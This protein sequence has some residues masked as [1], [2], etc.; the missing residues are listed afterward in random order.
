MTSENY[1]NNTDSSDRYMTRYSSPIISRGLQLAKKNSVA[2]I[3]THD[4]PLSSNQ[5][6]RDAKYFFNLAVEQIASSN[7]QDALINL[8]KALDIDPDYYDAYTVRSYSIYIPLGYYQDAIDDY[9]Q[10]LRLNPKNV[11]SLTNRGWVYAQLGCYFKAFQDYDLAL[12]V[13]PDCQIAYMNRGLSY[14]DCKNYQKAINDFQQVIEINPLNADAYHNK[15]LNLISLENYEHALIN[16]KK[17]IGINSEYINAHL[18]KGLCC[19]YLEKINQA[20]EAFSCAIE[21]N[22][23]YAKNYLEQFNEH[24][25]LLSAVILILINRGNIQHQQ[26]NPHAALTNYELALKIDPNCELAILKRGVTRYILGRKQGA[27]ADYN[28]VVKLD[29]KNLWAYLLRAKVFYE[30]GYDVQ[31]KEDSIKSYILLGNKLSESGDYKGAIESYTIALKIDPNNAEAYNRRST[32]R[33]AIGDYQGA[34]ED[35]QRVRMI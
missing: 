28:K 11:E 24:E 34:M 30:L 35:L 29:T 31:A 27:I 8:Q 5:Y 3:S 7:Y 9:T 25:K 23:E 19:I 18:H 33:S 22:N 12:I 4:K 20:A 26:Q 21:L 10:A 16:F 15:G 14:M 2:T 6:D 13:K 32:A 17:A 1:Q